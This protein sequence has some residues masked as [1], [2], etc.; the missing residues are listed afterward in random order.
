MLRARRRYGQNF[1]HD[2]NVIRR[3]IAEIS[4]DSNDQFA[5]IGGGLGALTLPLAQRVQRLDVIEIDER[6][7]EQL[8][9]LTHDAAN[10]H[11]HVADALDFDFASCIENDN[12]I[13][14]FHLYQSW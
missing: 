2:A 11:I 9:R 13:E 1:L 8:D 14:I 4:P 12:E 6:L 3:I 7:A 10:V 5:E